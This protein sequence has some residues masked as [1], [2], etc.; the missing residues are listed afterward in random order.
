M[1]IIMRADARP[2]SGHRHNGPPNSIISCV[3][4]HASF[5]SYGSR[6]DNVTRGYFTKRS[7]CWERRLKYSIGSLL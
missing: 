2:S 1:K 3:Y 5:F 7:R 4:N 6:S